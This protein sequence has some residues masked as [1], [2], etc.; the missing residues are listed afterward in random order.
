MTRSTRPYRP[1]IG[2]VAVGVGLAAIVTSLA[3]STTSAGRGF[4]F[5]FGAFIIF[6]GLL[7]GAAAFG[8]TGLVIGPI[9]LVITGRLLE[10]LHRPDLLDDSAVDKDVIVPARAS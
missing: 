10:T 9:I 1:W 8:F 4:A 2:W 7:G 6:F 5:G 3:G